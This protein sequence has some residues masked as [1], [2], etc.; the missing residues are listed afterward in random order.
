[1]KSNMPASSESFRRKATGLEPAAGPASRR[2]GDKTTGNF[3][4]GAWPK[5]NETTK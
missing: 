4:S 5:A 3:R 1:M 2:P